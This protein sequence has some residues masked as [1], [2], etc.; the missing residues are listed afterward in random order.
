M[1]TITTN[2]NASSYYDETVF[3]DGASGNTM[4]VGANR[5]VDVRTM[6]DSVASGVYKVDAD[7]IAADPATLSTA[8]DDEDT[9]TITV[10]ADGGVVGN[11]PVKAATDDAGVATVSPKLAYTD[12][13]GEVTFTVTSV[14]DGEATITFYAGTETDTTVVTVATP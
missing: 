9:V 8:P 11:Y 5:P 14:A 2:W 3:V 6:F 12:G 10:E 1:R 7:S 13:N 4:T